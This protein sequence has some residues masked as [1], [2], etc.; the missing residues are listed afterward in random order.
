MAV[1]DYLVL[2]PL[3]EEWRTVR[4][5]LC[6]RVS[7]KPIDAITYYP[8]RVPVDQKWASGEYLVV[9]A[10][11]GDKTAGLAH[12]GVFSAHAIGAWR[13]S[14]VAATPASPGARAGETDARGC[15]RLVAYHRI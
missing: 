3:D 13:P 4:S 12:A 8:W 11:M 2:T 14:R 9:G 15:R 5:V 6:P 7:F 10:S 1:V